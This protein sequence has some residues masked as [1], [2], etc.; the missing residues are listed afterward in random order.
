MFYNIAGIM[1][2][3]GNI[4]IMLR[5]EQN[6]TVHHKQLH[7]C[8]FG[9]PFA[10]TRLAIQNHRLVHDEI[11][12]NSYTDSASDPSLPLGSPFKIAALYMT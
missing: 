12:T 2:E 5:E 4:C 1:V 11:C 6:N 9:I 8:I 3:L 7:E 10:T